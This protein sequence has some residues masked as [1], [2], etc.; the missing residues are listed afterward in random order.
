M[1]MVVSGARIRSLG[2]RSG[3]RGCGCLSAGAIRLSCSPGMDAGV[4]RRVRRRGRFRPN[5]ENWTPDLGDSGS[6]NN[7]LEYYTDFRRDHHNAY[8]DGHGHLVIRAQ[9][10]SAVP[11]DIPSCVQT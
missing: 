10:L 8:L 11:G 7:E 5:P 3:C 2:V 9:A 4:E 6:G 1:S